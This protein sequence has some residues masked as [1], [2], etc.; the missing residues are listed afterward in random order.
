[1]SAS[2]THPLLHLNEWWV[3]LEFHIVQNNLALLQLSLSLTLP[4]SLM[5]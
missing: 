4:L 1:M 2:I 3:S 5:L